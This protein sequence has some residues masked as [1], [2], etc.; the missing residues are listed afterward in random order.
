MKYK[1]KVSGD[2]NSN[3]ETCKRYSEVVDEE[4]KKCFWVFL[5]VVSSSKIL[6]EGAIV[7]F[8][9]FNGAF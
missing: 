9:S 3:F 1:K 5:M 2:F 6:L 4:Q 7:F 8:I